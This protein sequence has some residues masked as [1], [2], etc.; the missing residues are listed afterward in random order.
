MPGTEPI[1]DA[2][3][4]HRYKAYN[5]GKKDQVPTLVK[6]AYQIAMIK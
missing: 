3:H 1:E 4:S 5:S 6:L 2:S